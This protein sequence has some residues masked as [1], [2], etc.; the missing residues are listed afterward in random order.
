MSAS[1]DRPRWL[2]EVHVLRQRK[3]RDDVGRVLLEGLR[4]VSA[5]ASAGVPVE[6]LIIAPEFYSSER[7]AAVVDQLSGIGVRPRRVRPRQFSRLSYKAEG[8]LAVVRHRVPALGEGPVPRDRPLVILDALSDPG[9]LGSVLRAAN[10]F[11]GSVLVV[12]GTPKLYHPKALRASMGALFHTPTF[13][14][15]RAQAVRWIAGGGP[16]LLT[17]VPEGPDSLDDVAWSEP[18]ACVIGNEKRGVHPDWAD[19]AS[20]SVSI[21]MTGIV[22]SLNAATSA[23]L[24]LW[25]CRQRRAGAR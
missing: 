17:L 12:E 3:G 25:E 23:S 15:D 20:A 1:P 6:T 18:L 14:A 4:C 5:A 16:P 19:V 11:G 8:L 24:V 21:P 22:D 2:E 9:N 7:C 13:T 10:A